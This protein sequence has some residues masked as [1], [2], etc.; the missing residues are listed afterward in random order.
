MCSVRFPG[1]IREAG[2]TNSAV[3]SAEAVRRN[4]GRATP[5][6]LRQSNTEPL[7]LR[8]LLFL[9]KKGVSFF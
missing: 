9:C 4:I 7:K 1:G 3:L 6:K 8:V 5:I 2:D